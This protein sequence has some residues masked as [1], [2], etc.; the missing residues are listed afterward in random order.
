MI[1]TDFIYIFLNLFMLIVFIVTGRLI[2]KDKKNYWKYAKW[3]VITFT[4]ILGLRLNR[5]HDYIH[6]MEVYRYDL[7]KEQVLFTLFNHFLK[8]LDTGAH[9]IF[10]WY[11][12]A[13]ILG[14][15]FFLKSIREYSKWVLPLFL[16]SFTTFS[17]YMIR[18]AF[19]YTFVF[20]FMFFMFNEKMP[21]YKRWACMLVC[22]LLS[23]S[24]HSANGITCIIDIGLYYTIKKPFPAFAT[25]PLYIIASFYL[26]KN[27]DFSYLNG[28]LSFLGDQNDKF[29]AYTDNAD[30]W[31]GND[32]KE[33]IY[34][35][36]PIIKII[37]TI[38]E[39][40]LIYLGYY[41]L[42]LKKNQKMI[43]FYNLF[44]CGAIVSQCFYS[45]EI[46]RRMGDIMYWYWAFPLAYVLYNKKVIT[47]TFKNK[48]V[49]DFMMMSLLFYAYE[50]L[51]YLFLR[52]PG[53]YKFL[54]D[55]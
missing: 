46:L 36:N 39:C 33:N 18:Q 25:I 49:L 31:F 48:L 55:L 19:G 15:M 11:S 14:A 30:R 37:Q 26:Q 54:W 45:L 50:Y 28:I 9:W 34:D 3:P 53:M 12:G 10:I 1:T 38:G 47:T 5:G 52:E 21:K 40:S 44:I 8:S 17:E 13:F 4:L 23:Y 51:K 20:I 27:F 24:I 7:E 32:A 35:R 6:Y 43:F 2:S 41:I 22:F 42:Q 16:I 29:S